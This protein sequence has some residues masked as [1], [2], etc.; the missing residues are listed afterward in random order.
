HQ[1]AV[2]FLG[3]FRF[4][5]V[6]V[7]VSNVSHRRLIGGIHLEYS[8][9]CCH[10][11][12]SL[13]QVFGIHGQWPELSSIGGGQIK[14][15]IEKFRIQLNCLSK[16]LHSTVITFGGVFANTVIQM[17]SSLKFVVEGTTGRRYEKRENRYQCCPSCHSCPY[18]TLSVHF[19]PHLTALL[20]FDHQPD[21]SHSG[22]FCYVDHLD[23]V[24]KRQ[25][26]V[27]LHEHVLVLAGTIDLEESCSKPIKRH[28]FLV[29]G[30]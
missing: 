6:P 22:T 2:P 28:R 29:D 11:L 7:E 30:H 5:H 27:G 21:I 24:T 16:R 12:L 18:S 25:I 15:G 19:F 13:F 1:L 26:F 3:L 4:V 14:I 10:G 17:V 8:F 9:K 20:S 23:H